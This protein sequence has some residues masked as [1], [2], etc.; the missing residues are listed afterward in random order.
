MEFT[1]WEGYYKQILKDFDFSRRWDEV[2]AVVLVEQLSRKR[3][4]IIEERMLA[5]L[6]EGKD[7]RVIADSDV[8]LKPAHIAKGMR[9]AADGATS[10]L[11]QM[12]VVP[13]LVVTDLDGDVQD[14]VDANFSGA[15]CMIHAHGDNI[16]ELRTWTQRFSGRLAGTTQA[17]PFGLV[18]NFGGFTDG[19]R[20]ALLAR[21]F[22]ARTITLVGF[23][24][25][26]PKQKEGKDPEMKKRKL[27]WAKRL[28]EENVPDAK[29]VP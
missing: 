17:R 27:A 3:E 13:E 16:E 4:T 5:R 26:N 22:K 29:W 21:H 9:I 10:K 1:V 25:D 18:Y 28:I 11:K 23:D 15:L 20:A 8:E 7:V 12:G 24:F 14:Q 6:I 2:A 19:D